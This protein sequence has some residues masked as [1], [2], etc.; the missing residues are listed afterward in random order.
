MAGKTGESGA[1]CLSGAGTAAQVAGK[2][3]A[4]DGA[5]TRENSPFSSG[6]KRTETRQKVRP[7]GE[8]GTGK[9][10]EGK[11]L[12]IS[13]RPVEGPLRRE[14]SSKARARIAA[15]RPVERQVK[16]FLPTLINGIEV[17]ALVDSGNLW[18][19]VVSYDLFCQLGF[20]KKDLQPLR[21]PITLSTA[22][23][24]QELEILGEPKNFLH[25]QLGGGRT[26]FKI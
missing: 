21:N 12:S 22:K 23:E 3:T 11:V 20:S 14:D 2:K 19:S 1:D 9:G 25:L 5:E 18:R 26:R 8:I 6:E 7:N 16:Q 24:G 13:V 15:L 10:Q 4:G 17:L